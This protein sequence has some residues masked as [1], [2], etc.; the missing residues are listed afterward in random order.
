M[1]INGK[2]KIEKSDGSFETPDITSNDVSKPSNVRFTDI[3]LSTTFKP[4]ILYNKT[5]ST[6]NGGSVTLPQEL[7]YIS[8]VHKSIENH[9]LIKLS[10]NN[11]G[12][13]NLKLLLFQKPIYKIYVDTNTDRKIYDYPHKQSNLPTTRI[14]QTLSCYR[15]NKSD[16]YDLNNMHGKCVIFQAPASK[17]NLTFSNSQLKLDM[18]DYIKYFDTQPLEDNKSRVHYITHT[19][20]T[21]EDI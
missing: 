21:T 6:S 14:F 12:K 16:S 19:P 2:K 1:Y 18:S 10:N 11:I 17:F 8:P 4:S 5:Q 15:I 20:S 13:F 3:P 9:D 7:L